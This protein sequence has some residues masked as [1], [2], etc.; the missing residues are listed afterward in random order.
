MD[1]IKDIFRKGNNL[2]EQGQVNVVCEVE[3]TNRVPIF[4]CVLLLYAALR[5]QE[6]EYASC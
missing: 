5:C 2:F 6:G 3:H 1:Y 4:F